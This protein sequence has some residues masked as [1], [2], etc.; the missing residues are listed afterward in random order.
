MVSLD[1]QFPDSDIPESI[2]QIYRGLMMNFSDK[3]Q[4]NN[5]K[6]SLQDITIGETNQLTTI[7]FSSFHDAMGNEADSLF[8]F[9]FQPDRILTK[10][11]AERVSTIFEIFEENYNAVIANQK[12]TKFEELEEFSL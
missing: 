4:S 3:S 6:Q 2:I 9:H 10:A 12:S 1:S 11:L 7:D 5:W 8:E